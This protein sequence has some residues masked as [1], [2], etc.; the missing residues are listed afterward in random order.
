MLAMKFQGLE[1]KSGHKM[2]GG[3]KK[4]GRGRERVFSKWESSLIQ[5]CV[6]GGRISHW[7]QGTRWSKRA[8][9]KALNPN[10][11]SRRDLR[12]FAR[13]W[14]LA[15]RRLSDISKRPTAL[16]FPPIKHL[17]SG[18]DGNGETLPGGCLGSHT[19]YFLPLA[20]SSVMVNRRAR[21]W[22]HFE[23][24]FFPPRCASCPFFPMLQCFCA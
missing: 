14:F 13:E 15:N 4:N 8:L 24:T 11:W 1:S 12:R 18:R 19:S 5:R 20:V 7:T 21:D 10:L 22:R 17:T 16:L 2:E 23:P 3:G 6:W 9:P